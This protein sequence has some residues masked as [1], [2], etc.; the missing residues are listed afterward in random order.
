[1]GVTLGSTFISVA[2]VVTLTKGNFEGERIYLAYNSSSQSRTEE[3]QSKNSKQEL[4]GRPAYSST[5]PYLSPRNSTH[6]QRSITGTTL[7]DDRQVHPYTVQEDLPRPAVGWILQHQL[8]TKTVPY[9]Y[10]PNQYD[11]GNSSIEIL[12]P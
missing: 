11:L 9:R 7:L 8:T 2:G 3:R 10:S 6:S 5:Q 1:M 12:F 4:A